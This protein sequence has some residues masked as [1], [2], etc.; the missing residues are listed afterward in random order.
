MEGRTDIITWI[1]YRPP[2]GE[3]DLPLEKL[4]LKQIGGD[5]REGEEWLY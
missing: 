2:D 4:P 1:R 5:T 3:P